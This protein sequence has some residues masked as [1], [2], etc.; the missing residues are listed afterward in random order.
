MLADAADVI[1]AL[2][3][4]ALKGT[5]VAFDERIHRARPHA[6][7]LLVA[8][9]LR[10]SYLEKISDIQVG[11]VDPFRDLI[12]ISAGTDAENHAGRLSANRGCR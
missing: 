4:D 3:L 7:Q 12:A 8:R 2:T 11:V 1:G 10:R 6:G 9:N 5:D